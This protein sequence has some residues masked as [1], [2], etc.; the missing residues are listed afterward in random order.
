M[1]TRWRAIAITMSATYIKTNYSWILVFKHILWNNIEPI[2]SG[3]IC[4][5]RIYIKI[6]II[7]IFLCHKYIY[8]ERVMLHTS[9]IYK[10]VRR[11]STRPSTSFMNT[12]YHKKKIG[13]NNSQQFKLTI[14]RLVEM[15]LW[16]ERQ[17][18]SSG[19]ELSI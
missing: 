5:T 14:S 13:S 7:Y 1:R 9:Y 6:C 15:V 12:I 19:K 18:T 16:C 8:I 11:T 2:Y 3:N 4:T 10:P 17:A